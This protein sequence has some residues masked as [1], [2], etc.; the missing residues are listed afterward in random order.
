MICSRE[1]ISGIKLMNRNSFGILAAVGGGKIA[2]WIDPAGAM[3]IA[4][5]IGCL[6]CRNIFRKFHA[7]DS[8]DIQASYN[9]CAVSPLRQ[10]T[11]I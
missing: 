2:W 10:N 9:S 7:A 5:V 11:R 3:I 1:S 6:W 8:A 4:T